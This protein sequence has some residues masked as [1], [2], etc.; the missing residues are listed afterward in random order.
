MRCG[1]AVWQC[2]ASVEK[3]VWDGGPSVVLPLGLQVYSTLP[4]TKKAQPYCA[5]IPPQVLH[6]AMRS[7][8]RALWR[9]GEGG[10]GGEG[11][12]GEE[13]KREKGFVR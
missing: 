10:D 8:V 3:G 1:R 2:G 9:G 4:P 7:A 12:G 13:E 5:D 6:R 11:E